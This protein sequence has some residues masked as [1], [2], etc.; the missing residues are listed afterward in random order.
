MDD[1]WIQKL[2]RAC[3]S[4]QIRRDLLWLRAQEKEDPESIASLESA[5]PDLR[6]RMRAYMA[7]KRPDLIE[8]PR[9]RR[10]AFA[11]LYRQRFDS[12]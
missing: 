3:E 2:E 8:D 12:I 7:E 6:A 10:L 9:Q 5:D 11:R 4:D 1:E